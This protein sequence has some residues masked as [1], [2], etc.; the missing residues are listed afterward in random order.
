METDSFKNCSGFTDEQIMAVALASGITAGFCGAILL[1][2]LVTLLILAIRPRSRDRM[3]KSVDKRLTIWL[4]AVTVLAELFLAL[5]L[6][7]YF[8]PSNMAFCKAD[9]FLTQYFGFVQLLFTLWISLTLFFE[10]C[11][12]MCALKLDC[13]DKTCCGC[14]IKIALEVGLYFAM[15]IVPAIMA[16]PFTTDS[17][18]PIGPWC[19]ILVARKTAMNTQLDAQHNYSTMECTVWTCGS[20]N[21]ST[22]CCSTVST[23]LFV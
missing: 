8:N 5:S 14:K 22:C 3:C 15:F 10:V 21:S 7:Y 17:Y 16:I 1:L 11:K 6:V 23:V 19:W 2:V 20:S 12:A 9:G 13:M 4:T 18:G